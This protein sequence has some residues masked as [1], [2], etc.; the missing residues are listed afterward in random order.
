MTRNSTLLPPAGAM[1][2]PPS[3][4]FMP[5]AGGGMSASDGSAPGS[6][7]AGQFGR[8][9]AEAR[10]M[11]SKA[12]A[13]AM[14]LADRVAVFTA[15]K[16]PGIK[17][18]AK[19][20]AASA[21]A[22]VSDRN[23]RAAFVS[24]HKR[25]LVI[26]AAALLLLT[27]AGYGLAKHQAT[28]AAKA[29]IDGFLAQTGL[30]TSLTYTDISASPFGSAVL[31]GV[32]VKWPSREIVAK[33]S[34]LTVSGIRTDNDALLA[35]NVAAD[36]FEVPVL[37]LARQ[38]RDTPIVSD[39]VGLGYTV[40]RGNLRLDVRFDEDKQTFSLTTSATVRDLGS[41]DLNST[42]GGVNSSVVGWLVAMSQ[43]GRQMNPGA[44]NRMAGQYGL[45]QAT[46]V[47]A[48]LTIDNR[49]WF[50][51]LHEIT[52]SNMPPDGT[53]SASSSSDDDATE[54]DLLRAGMDP[55]DAMAAAKAA[56]KWSTVGGRL[57]ITTR[58]SDPIP[59]MK[60]SEYFG[61]PVLNFDSVPEFIVLTKAK[62]SN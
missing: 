53:P 24:A 29:R 36:G 5:A 16:L 11:A 52:D 60:S 51:R 37:G 46:L 62:L 14:I 38:Y 8:A 23:A 54:T 35:A 44:F 55:S 47:D 2:L 18:R 6:M 27:G 59:L 30:A 22:T 9:G 1:L 32:T 56:S 49:G 15:E 28:I 20:M 43:S 17:H 34:S 33:I 7:P 61:L 45:M 26:G 19:E 41:L 50:E 42:F 58:I 13:E 10:D 4:K 57:Q 12:R 21:G 25:K 48:A 3:E 40:L 39:A 31:S